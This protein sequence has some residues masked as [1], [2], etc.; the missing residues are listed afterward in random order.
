V[1]AVL[2]AGIATAVAAW[3]L[4]PA[5][6][7]PL[8]AVATGSALLAAVAVTLVRRKATAS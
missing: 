4:F 5:D 1:P 8:T 6:V 3:L 7:I 2:L